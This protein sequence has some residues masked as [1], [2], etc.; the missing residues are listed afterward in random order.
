MSKQ[1]LEN[2]CFYSVCLILDQLH[3]QAHATN[4]I[5]YFQLF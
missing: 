5:A 3:H 1:P 4:F 2:K